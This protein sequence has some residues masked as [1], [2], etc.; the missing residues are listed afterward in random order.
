MQEVMPVDTCFE[1]SKQK[2]LVH[3]CNAEEQNQNVAVEKNKN[4]KNYSLQGPKTFS[5]SKKKI[6][7]LVSVISKLYKQQSGNE[8]QRVCEISLGH[9]H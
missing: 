3:A 6:Q 5:H 1:L 8:A 2:M 4:R 7:H 9:C